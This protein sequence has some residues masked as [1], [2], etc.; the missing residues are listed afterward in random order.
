MQYMEV[1]NHDDFYSFNGE[2]SVKVW[3]NRGVGVM[4]DA[5]IE[6]LKRVER[7]L[8]VVGTYYIQ[9]ERGGKIKVRGTALW[10]QLTLF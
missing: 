5:A 10:L 2:G 7:E 8:L 3:D 6:D 9:Q 1:E 4:Y